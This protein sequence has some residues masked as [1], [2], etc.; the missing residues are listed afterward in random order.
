MMRFAANDS[1]KHRIPVLHFYEFRHFC[2]IFS[3]EMCCGSDYE[4]FLS[5]IVSCK[6]HVKRKCD[7]FNELIYSN[8]IAV[9]GGRRTVLVGIF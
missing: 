1:E 3:P 2:Y 7:S 5:T 9:V 8:K 6:L 4:E